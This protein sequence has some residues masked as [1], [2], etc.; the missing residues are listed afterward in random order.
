MECHGLG[1]DLDLVLECD[2]PC[3]CGLYSLSSSPHKLCDAVRPQRV[4]PGTLLDVPSLLCGWQATIL[5]MDV[6]DFTRYCGR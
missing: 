1:D 3:L 4:W 2:L 5:F 6:V